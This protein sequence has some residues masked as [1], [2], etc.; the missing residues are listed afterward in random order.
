MIDVHVGRALPL[1]ENRAQPLRVRAIDG[2]DQPVRFGCAGEGRG[3]A[4]AS[5]HKFK[6]RGQ[7]VRV[8]DLNILA[9]GLQAERETEG[10]AVGIAIRA[11]VGDHQKALVPVAEFLEGRE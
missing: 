3:Q 8:D 1:V 2:E 11:D 10:R 7:S 6:K 5:G 4:F 9:H